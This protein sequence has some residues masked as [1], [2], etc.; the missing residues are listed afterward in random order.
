MTGGRGTGRRP[1]R[2]GDSSSGAHPRG[3]MVEDVQFSSP[4]DVLELIGRD[5]ELDLVRSFLLRSADH[6]GALLFT[7]EAGV[8]KSALLDQACSAAAMSGA[9]V[10]R[11]A[12]V[13]FEAEVSSAGLNQLFLPLHDQ[14]ADLPDLH[15]EALTAT[16]GV[17]AGPAAGRLVVSAAALAL[18]RRAAADGP[19]LVV[20]DDLQWLDRSSAQVLGFIARRL[21]GG[22]VG[23]LAAGGSEADSFLLHAGLPAHEVPPLDEVAATGLLRARFPELVA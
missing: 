12:G 10:L 17:G 18:L 1:P 11:A 16:L 21:D 20:V 5:S 23:L 14:L 13:E 9:R 4:R 3:T 15:R 2:A 7:G 8:G 22:R 6:G 19:V